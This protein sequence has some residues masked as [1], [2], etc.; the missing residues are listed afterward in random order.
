MKTEIEIRRSLIKKYRKELYRPFIEA[1]KKYNLIESGD[2]IMSCVSGGKDSIL[3]SLL[4][5][6]LFDHGIQNFELRH[7]MM[8]P[9][10]TDEYVGGIKEIYKNLGIELEIFK[11]DIFE[12]T[13]KIANENPCFMCARMRRGALYSH[14]QEIGFNK[15]AL[16][17]HMDDV[18]ETTLMNMIMQGSFRNM[19]PILDSDN[20]PGIKLI[21][22]LYLVKEYDIIRFRDYAE[23]VTLD[24]ACMLTKKNALSTRDRIK[25]LLG[26]IEKDFPGA[27]KNIQNSIE[28]VYLDTI[29]K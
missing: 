18:V 20:F 9:G 21:R 23:L 19:L 25:T 12:V 14:A 6:E 22:P 11:T 2:K 24:C 26:Q 4:L 3:L 16:G 28:N 27:K 8:N 17:H 13:E 1:I 15:I 29:I 10:F 5:Q 7:V